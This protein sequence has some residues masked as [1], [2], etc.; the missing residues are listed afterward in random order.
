MQPV[1]T[2]Q[3][4]VV[5]Y[6]SYYSK[7]Q[8]VSAGTVGVK[9]Y[10]RDSYAYLISIVGPGIEFVGSI[11]EAQKKFSD[12]FWQQPNTRFW[13]ANANFDEL[14]TRRYW[15]DAKGMKPWHCILDQG[16]T[17]QLPQ[18]LSGIARALWGKKVDKSIRDWMDGKHWKDLD[19]QHKKEVTDYCLSDALEERHVLETLRVPSTIEAKIAAHTRMCNLR[20]VRIDAD[21]LAQDREELL[22]F[23]HDAFLRIPWHND[24]APLSTSP[25]QPGR[26]R[27]VFRCRRRWRKM[28]KSVRAWSALTRSSPRSSERCGSTGSPTPWSARSTASPAASPTT[29]RWRW[30]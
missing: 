14:W 5:D 1:D 6:E 10:V 22:K 27:R 2:K 12:A 23:Q 18:S 13:A 11:E 15:P 3:D 8:D 4:I 30:S 28:T 21:R 19:D 29:A 17:S 16:A 9:N 26:L 7:K 24:E 25:W 20:G